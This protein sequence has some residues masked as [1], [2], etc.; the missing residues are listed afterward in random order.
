MMTHKGHTKKKKF[1]SFLKTIIQIQLN[2]NLFK[3][4]GFKTLLKI[5]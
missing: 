2:E 4:I 5:T 3:N 1:L